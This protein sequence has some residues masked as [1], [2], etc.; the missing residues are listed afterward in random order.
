M[1]TGFAPKKV[2]FYWM[3]REQTAPQFFKNTL[4]EIK[5]L[6]SHGFLDI[7]IYLTAAV[8]DNDLR[9]TIGRVWHS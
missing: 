6:D 4:E 9:V 3:T 7:N 5:L 1:K 8:P 2:Y